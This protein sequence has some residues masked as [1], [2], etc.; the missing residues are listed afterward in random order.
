MYRVVL[1]CPLSSVNELVLNRP[2]LWSGNLKSVLKRDVFQDFFYDQSF[3]LHSVGS[4]DR[5]EINVS[6]TK[7]MDML[8]VY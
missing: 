1:F 2:F 7:C 5:P 8:S 4:Y 3:C 6:P